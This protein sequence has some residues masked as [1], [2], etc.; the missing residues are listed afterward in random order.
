MG[1]KS[2]NARVDFS[3]AKLWVT[4]RKNVSGA[5]WMA[6]IVWRDGDGK[7]QTKSHTCPAK[8]IRTE[9]A[10]KAEANRW[11]NE[12]R[13]EQERDAAQEKAQAERDA[14][15]ARIDSMPTVGEYVAEYVEQQA[16][17]DVLEPSTCED[18][19][20]SARRIAKTIGGEKVCGLGV[21]EVQRW[22]HDM[23]GRYSH[24]VVK[25]TR[26]LLG[27]AMGQAVLEGLVD[28]NPVVAAKRTRTEKLADKAARKENYLDLGG[29]SVLLGELDSMADAPVTIAARLA[30]LAGLREGEVCALMWRDVDLNAGFLT[31]RHA[32]SE[33]GSGRPYLKRQKN[34]A[35]FRD[36]PIMADL[37]VAL[38]RWRA[39]CARAAMQVGADL[40]MTYVIGDP[41]RPVTPG[42]LA[43]MGP[44][45][46]AGAMRPAY[47]SREWRNLARLSKA[48]GELGQPVTFHNLRHTFGT[49][50]AN[51]GRASA[52][53]LAKMMGHANT[54]TTKK[55]YV[56]R[57]REVERRE[58]KK[59]IEQAE[60]AGAVREPRGE[61]LG[62]GGATGTDGR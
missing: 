9:K 33:D 43:E 20:K 30:M 45:A 39:T 34:D 5:P 44:E 62:M 12:L 40:G 23:E 46:A 42:Q 36:V 53:Q 56:A 15:Q 51:E 29:R 37:A 35:T 25:K 7:R 26:N 55:Y 14:E 8:S 41:T 24:G 32:I 17:A 60:R 49:F 11:F 22:Q 54:A 16:A 31:V 38:R 18:Y 57:D 48:R 58:S 2:G 59:A 19:R 27:Q 47:L 21:A 52:E 28:S 10:A 3:N 50:M 4:Q 61:V 1:R 6:T 13:A